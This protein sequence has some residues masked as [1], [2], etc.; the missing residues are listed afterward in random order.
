MHYYIKAYFLI[1][2]HEQPSKNNE[3]YED[4]HPQL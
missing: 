3:E 1:Y 2:M 4:P